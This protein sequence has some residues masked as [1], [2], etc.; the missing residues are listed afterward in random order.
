MRIRIVR[1]CILEIMDRQSALLRW[2]A[3][4][5]QPG[6]EPDRER[7]S[8]IKDLDP[9]W[10]EALFGLSDVEK[11]RQILQTL[12]SAPLQALE[13]LA[14]FCEA[15]SVSAT[16]AGMKDALQTVLGF[17]KHADPNLRSSAAEF[18]AR[19]A[20]HNPNF[21][22][23]VLDQTPDTVSVLVRIMLQDQEE[24]VKAKAILA[25]SALVRHCTAALQLAIQE[26]AVSA[27]AQ[28][29]QKHT[30][31]VFFATYLLESEEAHSVAQQIKQTQA[32]EHAVKWSKER[33]FD[34]REKGIRF[35]IAFV[36]TGEKDQRIQPLMSWLEH[37]EKEWAQQ[38]PEHP[39]DEIGQ[40]LLELGRFMN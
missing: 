3:E 28:L 17:L 7:L 25:L 10:Y 33:N 36:K 13:A 12:D 14:D 6:Q 31:A 22:Q 27:I 11:L 38:D 24:Q 15:A 35:L 39:S 2:A 4:H 29:M 37:D 8:S 5:Q 40:L 23:A 34:A 1:H 30:R 21:Q 20:A 26:N 32:I 18:L 16:L 19:A 9:G